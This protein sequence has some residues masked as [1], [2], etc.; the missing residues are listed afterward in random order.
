VVG[1]T[2]KLRFSI[3]ALTPINQL[4]PEILCEA[5]FHLRPVVRG[6]PGQP[7][8]T[9]QPFEDL[10]TVTHTCQH[11]RVAA[12]AAADLWSQ[13]IIRGSR[14]NSDDLARLVI[15]RSGESPLDADVGYRLVVVVPH[16]NRLR[17]LWCK[18]ST[19][20]DSL[21][22]GNHPVP[23]LEALH[24]SPHRPEPESPPLPTL[25]NR[26]SPSL[27]ELA[28]DGYK[29]WPNNQF[30]G[31][32]SF[33][34]KLSSQGDPHTLLIQ[35]LE[36]LRDSPQLEELFLH[37][38]LVNDNPPSAHSIPARVSLHALQKLHLSYT[39]PILVRQFLGSVDFAPNGIAMQFTNVT[40]DPD[41]MFH[42]TLPPEL[43]LQAATS[44]EIIYTFSDG[45]IIQGTNPG[46]RIRVAG[47]LDSGED[48]VE[49]FSRL[50]RRTSPQFPLRELWI[51]IEREGGYKFPPLSQFNDLEKLT[52]RSTRGDPVGQL[53]R[54]LD[55][56]G[57]VPCPL[58]STLHLLGLS[59][60][61]DLSKILKARS[62]AGCR[63]E[64]LGLGKVH[65]PVESV[66]MLRG[67]V[68]EVEVFD[69]DWEPC[70]MELPAV[71]M[72]ETGGWWESW[73]EHYVRWPY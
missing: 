19:I 3:N 41:Q 68:E 26:G 42:A 43:S 73:T 61:E 34:L 32:S 40:S 11:W 47:F 29:P 53:L 46:M 6:G 23:F 4:P 14:G 17:T 56:D 36:M 9:R 50:A 38:D 24:I 71:C 20:N 63:L 33:Y 35:L 1:I 44:L 22:F 59:G 57:D 16:T 18:G 67:Y 30:G 21:N 39:P 10:L 66:T 64:R 72:G 55:A 52:V 13:L 31:L 49:I 60:V 58:L 54:M 37:L 69:E 25:F 62:D 48:Q 27:R 28:I 15:S 2:S 7:R 8:R 51:H 45:L 12:I 5:F 65:V 70:G